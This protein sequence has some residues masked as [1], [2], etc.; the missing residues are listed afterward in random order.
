MKFSQYNN[1]GAKKKTQRILYRTITLVQKDNV[2][3]RNNVP[4][5]SI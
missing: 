3:N 2:V 4:A 5:S 1:V